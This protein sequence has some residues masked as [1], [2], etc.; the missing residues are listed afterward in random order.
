[1]KDSCSSKESIPIPNMLHERR[2]LLPDLASLQHC[3]PANLGAFHSPEQSFSI[4]SPTLHKFG[5]H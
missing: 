3:V 1:M 2:K 5:D 4:S